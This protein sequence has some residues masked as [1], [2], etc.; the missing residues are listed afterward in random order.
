M[1]WPLRY[2]AHPWH[3]LWSGLDYEMSYQKAD[4][5]GRLIIPKRWS[6]S[7]STQNVNLISKT[8][9]SISIWIHLIHTLLYYHFNWEPFTGMMV[10]NLE[11]YVPVI[12]RWCLGSPHHCVFLI[13]PCIYSCNSH[14]SH[15]LCECTSVGWCSYW[16]HLALSFPPLRRHWKEMWLIVTEQG[17]SDELVASGPPFVEYSKHS[18]TGKI[19]SHCT[20]NVSC[21]G[22]RNYWKSFWE[23]TR[24]PYQLATKLMRCLHGIIQHKVQSFNNATVSNH[25]LILNESRHHSKPWNILEVHKYFACNLSTAGTPTLSGIYAV[26]PLLIYSSATEEVA[27][28]TTLLPQ[29]FRKFDTAMTTLVLP[30]PS[31]QSRK[32]S[33]G[34]LKYSL[35][36]T[37]W[38]L[39]DSG[40]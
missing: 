40:P 15:S 14:R 30:V 16:W 23:V 10:D 35:Q 12:T 6:S 8:I 2:N 38:R 26:L 32:F 22:I 4:F 33:C 17:L 21:G 34:W 24:K 20:G 27:T 7:Q 36:P 19:T 5:Y 25:Y 9:L 29:T 13:C 3:G 39:E 18:G 28:D 11:K 1:D 37:W 31:Q